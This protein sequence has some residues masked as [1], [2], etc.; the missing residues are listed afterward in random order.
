MISE[1]LHQDAHP[2]NANS[3]F[4]SFQCLLPG[5]EDPNFLKDSKFLKPLVPFL[6]N[7]NVSN[8][9][10]FQANLWE[11]PMA[12]RVYELTVDIESVIKE[13]DID[14]D[15]M[16]DSSKLNKEEQY[17][18]FRDIRR[19]LAEMGNNPLTLRYNLLFRD[20]RGKW[21]DDY[22][23]S[24]I[25]QEERS[26]AKLNNKAEYFMTENSIIFLHTNDGRVIDDNVRK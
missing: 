23:I 2:S 1:D 3:C 4:P 8:E 17:V 24:L 13:W 6:E 22:T 26:Q 25:L 7:N 20:L 12:K 19:E 11:F 21:Q 10:R 5:F 14:K 15:A 16:F 18:N 9:F